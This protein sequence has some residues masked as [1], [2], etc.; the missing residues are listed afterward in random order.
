[1]KKILLLIL[2]VFLVTGC[3]S[4]YEIVFD[5]TIDEKITINYDGDIYKVVEEF[6]FD[7]DSFYFESELVKSRIPSL[8]EF[9]DYYKKNIEVKNNKSIITLNYKY[10]YENFE[11]SYLISECFEKSN[12]INNDEYYYVSLGGSFY[13]YGV[14]HFTLKMKT[15]YKV[16]RSNADR[17]ENGYYIWDIETDNKDDEVELQLSKTVKKEENEKEFK[18]SFELVFG[19]VLIFVVIGFFIFRKRFINE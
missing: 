15:D 3:T 7:G 19:I 14:D 12:F 6:E 10:S 9:K 4:S 13:C 8:I 16:L 1:M 11:N 2:L 17:E 18:V 5:D